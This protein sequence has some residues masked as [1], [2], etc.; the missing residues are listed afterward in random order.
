MFGIRRS[1]AGFTL[2]FGNMNESMELE[3]LQNNNEPVEN[4]DKEQ[5]S[6]SL[7]LVKF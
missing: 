6:T 1:L 7:R 5:V 3:S 2:H 4:V